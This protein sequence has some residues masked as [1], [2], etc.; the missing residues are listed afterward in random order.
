MSVEQLRHFYKSRSSKPDRFTYD[1]DGNLIELNK[2]GSILKTI[3]LPEYRPPTY[4]ELDEMEKKR[5]EAIAVATRE[6]EN[7]RK[8]L[9]EL[10]SRPDTPESEILRLNRKVKEA[11]IK[12]LSARFPLRFTEVEY[13]IQIKEIDFTKSFEKRKFPYPFYFL[14]ETPFSLQD[15]YVRIGKAPEK[16][17][18]SVAEAKAKEMTETASSVILFAD[19]ETNDYGFMSLKWT[20]SLE[21]NG[22]IYNSAHQALAG[23]L[24]KEFNDN[25]NLQRIMIAETPD[26]ITYNLE[27][28]PGDPD[29]NETKWNDLTK[30][31]IYDIN[32]AKFNQYPELSGRLLETKNAI[33]G[34]YLPDDNLI[35]IGISLDNIQSKNPVNWTGQNILGKALM[36]IRDKMY[37]EQRLKEQEL[38][39]ISESA[40]IPKRKKP[41]AAPITLPGIP[42]ES[43]A[44]KQEI[45]TEFIAPT[46]EVPEVQLGIP[47][48]IRRRP[49]PVIAST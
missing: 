14:K 28:V 32:I 31:L 20:V 5:S 47:R 22:T 13:G 17:L 43:V 29:V 18:T 26:E 15:Q 41:K 39:P 46:K 10:V 25:T 19:P 45:P 7:S 2:D 23:E 9:R 8:H 40:A 33:L 35:G 12:L 3:A 34:A 27:D 42:S 44:A 38:L 21:F 16:P 37:N 30:Q 4:E 6:Y 1:D 24:A 11:D 48:P 49:K 36:N